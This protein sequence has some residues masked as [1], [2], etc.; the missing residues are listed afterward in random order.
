MSPKRELRKW[1]SPNRRRNKINPNHLLI[2]LIGILSALLSLKNY[3][4]MNNSNSSVYF[5]PVPTYT[6]KPQ[7]YDHV[8]AGSSSTVYNLNY[9]AIDQRAFS[10]IYEGASVSELAKILSSYTTSQAQKARIIYSWIAHNIAYDV[11]AYLSGNYGDVSPTSILKNRRG[12]CSGY[13]NLYQALA[14]AMGLEAAIIEGSAKGVDYRVG[15][16]TDINHAWNAVKID[17]SW[18][19]LD[20]TWG[21]GTVNGT[22]FLRQF[23]PHY[24]ATPPS[25]FIYDH[26][27]VDSVWQLLNTR[28]TKQQFESLP[29][30]SPDF[31]KNGLKLVN[32][33]T[34]TIFAQ[35]ETEVIL[36]AP[37]QTNV[38]ARLTSQG[39]ILE[40]SYTLV[41]RKDGYISVKAAFPIPGTYELEIFSSSNFNAQTYPHA[42]TYKV[43]AQ[44]TGFQF[45]KTYS[46]FKQNQG[47][48]ST[49]VRNSLPHSQTVYFEIT[50]ENAL[51]VQIMNEFS[52]DW[53]ELKSTGNVFSG[54]A[55]IGNGK[56]SIV[57]K[58]P[59]DERYW[60][61]AE[62]N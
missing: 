25:E 18:Y 48:L 19:L 3:Q 49:P 10:I 44:S 38:T 8:I 33:S 14:E 59:G 53:V 13:A 54:Y 43:I 24:F 47:Y 7:Q 39:R 22:Q 32:Q 35:G 4:S 31:F 61:L 60:T 58:F 16:S 21:A 52:N 34:N 30:V 1:Q 55:K 6:Q 26:F 42:V 28:Y 46:I 20:A 50:V 15:N 37:N 45:P 51:S 41:Q 9:E 29:Q 11:A 23:N 17:N 40:D 27:P 5:Q 2:G 12:V 36:Q 62:Y 56:T 57:A